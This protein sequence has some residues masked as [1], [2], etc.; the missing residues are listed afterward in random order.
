LKEVELRGFYR[1]ARW[2]ESALLPAL[3]KVRALTRGQID[4]DHDTGEAQLRLLSD[5]TIP[6]PQLAEVLGSVT[7][8]DVESRLEDEI[9][10]LV[11]WG[12]YTFVASVEV[13]E[14][15]K[16]ALGV[17]AGADTHVARFR[18]V[19]RGSATP[20][21]CLHDTARAV[22]HD[23]K[24]RQR[25]CIVSIL[26][27]AVAMPALR[28]RAL[29]VLSELLRT[30]VTQSPDF[31][32]VPPATARA[33][34]TSAGPEACSEDRGPATASRGTAATA[35]PVKATPRATQVRNNKKARAELEASLR[36]QPSSVIFTD[37]NWLLDDALEDSAE[38]LVAAVTETRLSTMLNRL[39]KL[40]GKLMLF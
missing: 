33:G 15:C 23:S 31:V 37:A 20:L 38:Q 6:L 16:R 29:P 21:A 40:P 10:Q 17:G 27:D 22:I 30:S 7:L 25:R 28:A 35:P 9:R 36:A 19:A 2:Q 13:S 1:D 11:G 32:T 14:L 5:L 18:Q 12:I 26:K 8:W 3:R 4:D 39:D 24:L 34:T